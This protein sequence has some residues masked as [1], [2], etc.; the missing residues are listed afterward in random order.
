MYD[1][2]IV[3]GGIV[4]LATARE[5]LVRHPGAKLLL[6]EKEA[7]W[8]AHQS[9]RNSGVIHSGIYYKPGSLKAKL[10]RE[11]NRSMARFCHE[12]GIAHEICG[13]LVVATTDEEVPRLDA[14]GDRGRE[15]GI[16]VR[17][18]TSAEAKDIE[19]NIR[20]VAALLVPS[21]GIADYVGVCDRLAAI[22][23][24]FG[25]DL[26][27]GARLLSVSRHGS[28]KRLHTSAGDFECKLLV[29]CAGLHSDRVARLDDADP[30]A[31]VVPFRGEY[32]E[33]TPGKRHL[34]RGLVYPVP[35]PRFPFL[36]VHLTKTVDG[37]VH[38]GPNAVLAFAREGYGKLDVNLRDLAE[39]VGYAGFWQIAAKFWRDGA[40]EMARSFS[41]SRFTRSVQAMLP[42][43]TAA[44]LVPAR[45][46]IRAQVVTPEGAI[47]DDFLIVEGEGSLHVCNAPSPAATA[48]LEIAK[49]I[50]DRIP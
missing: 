39:I 21:T 28:V 3:G 2:A 50:C 48:S 16:E 29:T 46:G 33:L 12:H 32:Y 1:F 36:G 18:V 19:P 8:A 42:S 14:L 15:N 40:S 17:R 35:D 43:I 34:V 24:E 7:T 45:P 23:R 22:A 13:K 49:A 31:R 20:C 26:R 47:V 5:L 37:G 11:G 4:G 41:K 25:G 6:L 44:D 27:L 9:G 10:G 30:G 38:A